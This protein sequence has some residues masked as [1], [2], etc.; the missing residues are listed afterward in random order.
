MGKSGV[1]HSHKQM[2]SVVEVEFSWVSALR[3]VTF[4]C[5][6][7]PSMSLRHVMSYEMMA[8]IEWAGDGRFDFSAGWIP[9]NFVE[10]HMEPS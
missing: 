8:Y 9:L 1:L 5:E 3:L 6:M 2:L 10:K 4:R 7:L